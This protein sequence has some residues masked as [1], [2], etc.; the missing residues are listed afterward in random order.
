MDKKKYEKFTIGGEDQVLSDDVVPMSGMSFE[1]RVDSSAMS[2]SK[3][4]VSGYENG[5]IPAIIIKS[6]K[7][8]V[9]QIP[10]AHTRIMPSVRFMDTV[11]K[12]D[13]T[14]SLSL[15]MHHAVV[16]GQG[17]FL[18]IALVPPEMLTV[19]Y[20]IGEAEDG[21]DM[22]TNRKCIVE[23]LG[24]GYGIVKSQRSSGLQYVEGEDPKVEGPNKNKTK[25]KFDKSGP[26]KLNLKTVKTNISTSKQQEANAEVLIKLCKE[27]GF[28]DRT[29]AN[30]VGM[31]MGESGLI[32]KSELGYR[33]TS[34]SRIR[35]VFR[36]RINSLS[37]SQIE[38]LKKDDVK[39]FDYVYHGPVGSKRFNDKVKRSGRGNAVGGYKYRG[40]GYVQHTGITNYEKL[41]KS[42][43]FDYVKNPDL[44][45]EPEH[46][47]R[48]FIAYYK[49]PV[50]RR[51]KKDFNNIIHVYEA[52]FGG[53]YKNYNKHR[54]DDIKH[55]AGIANQWYKRIKAGKGNV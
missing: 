34:V 47:A 3:S 42:A 24:E 17:N 12:S 35:K 38:K 28:S 29:T 18:D 6:Q 10:P 41:S 13:S 44:L 45:N 1:E 30:F 31:A 39:F 11:E 15:Y 4:R 46:A 40:R 33:G 20:E 16:A 50:W 19:V 37:D 49:D 48:A 21:T 9:K 36:G 55:R 54:K 8:S 53:R 26:T 51:L 32:P 27:N 2:I 5:Y 23:M 7:I 43:G 14:E 52:T 22:Q 25:K